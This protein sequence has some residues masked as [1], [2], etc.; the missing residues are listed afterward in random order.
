[1]AP[2]Y[3]RRKSTHYAS[4]TKGNS[5][6]PVCLIVGVLT[7]GLVIA[8]AYFAGGFGSNIFSPSNTP[9]ASLPTTTPATS[10]NQTPATGVTK[11]LLHTSMGNI[12]IQLFEDKPITTQNFLNLVAA[13]KYDGTVFHRIM[14]TFMI[15]GG[16]IK[17]EWE[18]IQDEIG[19]SNHNYKYTI[20]MA[21][22]DKPNSASSS[23]FINTANNSNVNFDSTYTA[24]GKVIDGEDVVN[25]IAKVPVTANGNE[26][27]KPT[28]TV[29]LISATII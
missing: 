2:K 16:I 3:N 21:K 8:V 4:S 28:Q 15:Q 22:T 20:A 14:Q 10:P 6:K 25:A 13:G 7:I 24:F 12:T 18:T 9:E 23:F 19:S 26:M 11:V 1:M 5:K 17:G 29:T 27:S